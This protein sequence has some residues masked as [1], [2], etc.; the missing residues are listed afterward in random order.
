MMKLIPVLLP[1]GLVQLMFVK[2]TGEV[3]VPGEMGQ[4][5]II[6]ASCQMTRSEAGELAQ[7]LNKLAHTDVGR[8]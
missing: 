5:D 3:A 7:D 4:A 2:A 8:P 6:V 1:N